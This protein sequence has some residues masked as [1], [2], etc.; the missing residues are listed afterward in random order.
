MEKTGRLLTDSSMLY[1]GSQKYY[2]KVLDAYQLGSGQL[3]FLIF[4]YENEGITMNGLAQLGCY[5]K[6]TVTKG[7]QRLEEVGYVTIEVSPADKRVRTL[8]TT[9]KAKEIIGQIYLIRQQW[10]DQITQNMSEAEAALFEKL[11]SKAVANALDYLAEEEPELELS[12]IHICT[13]ETTVTPE[14]TSKPTESSVITNEPNNSQIQMFSNTT[15]KS[16][17]WTED[18]YPKYLTCLLYTSRQGTTI[19]LTTHNMEE[20]QEL[21]DRVAFLNEGH[22]VEEGTP[23]ALRLKYAEDSVELCYQDG[24]TLRVRKEPEASREM[25]IRDR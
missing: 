1:R 7:I 17:D 20:A 13:P 5:D 18:K 22:L 3:P 9:A 16:D 25:C 12:L 4:I 8:R 2:D 15:R 10:W 24:T 14:G 21:C 23:Q 19:F 11:Q 6:G